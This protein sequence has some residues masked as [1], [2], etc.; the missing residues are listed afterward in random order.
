[1]CMFDCLDAQAK[2]PKEGNFI[3]LAFA[4]GNWLNNSLTEEQKGK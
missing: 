2:S 3:R 1:M 4:K